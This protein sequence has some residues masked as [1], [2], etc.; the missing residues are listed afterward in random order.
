MSSTG[1]ATRYDVMRRQGLLLL[2]ASALTLASDFAICSAPSLSGAVGT[3]RSQARGNA[4]YTDNMD[5]FTSFPSTTSGCLVWSMQVHGLE[6]GYDT[7]TMTC[8]SSS[9]LVTSSTTSTCCKA[10]LRVCHVPLRPHV[11][12][13][14]SLTSAYPLARCDFLRMDP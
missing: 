10:N 3:L 6:S 7:V 14:L 11:Y 5:C 9:L 2:L 13:L 12:V 1:N 8:G 4:L